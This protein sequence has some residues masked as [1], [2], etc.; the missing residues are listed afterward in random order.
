MSGLSDADKT[1]IQSYVNSTIIP[2]SPTPTNDNLL[3]TLSNIGLNSDNKLKAGLIY[4]VEVWP[5]GRAFPKKTAWKKT[6]KSRF[7]NNLPLPKYSEKK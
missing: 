4:L 1:A 7:G 5:K 2:N 6:T 3:K